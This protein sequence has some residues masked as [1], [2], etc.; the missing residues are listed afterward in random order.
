MHFDQLIIGWLV[1]VMTRACVWAHAT[2]LSWK[3]NSNATI[4]KENRK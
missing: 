1:S 4:N 2:E 3:A